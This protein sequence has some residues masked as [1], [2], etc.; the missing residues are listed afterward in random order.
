M[1]LF[2]CLGFYVLGVF[3]WVVRFVG[4]FFFVFCWVFL[5]VGFFFLVCFLGVFVLVFKFYYLFILHF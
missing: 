1:G 4:G 2:V 3:W 5:V